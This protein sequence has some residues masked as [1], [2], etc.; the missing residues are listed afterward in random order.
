LCRSFDTTVERAWSGLI[1]LKIGP[2]GGFLV[3]A[4]MKFRIPQ[5]ANILLTAEEILASEE[6]LRFM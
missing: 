4:A 6:E 5:N 2:S 1:W 3:N